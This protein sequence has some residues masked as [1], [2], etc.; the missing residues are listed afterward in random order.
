[1]TEADIP[2]GPRASASAVASAA[3]AVDPQRIPTSRGLTRES[4]RYAARRTTRG[5]WRHRGLDA[6]AALTF[7]ATLA[8]F[9]ATLAIVSI[10]ALASGGKENAADRIT[11][12]LGEFAKP[13]TIASV[14]GPITEFLNLPNPGAAL[15]IGLVVTLWAVSSYATSFGRSINAI[16]EVQEGRRFFKFRALMIAVAGVLMVGFAIIGVIL[17]GTPTVA[18]AIGENLGIAEPWIIA[19]N[20]LKWPALVI[21]AFFIVAVLYYF[22]PNVKHLRLRWVSWGAAIALV[23]WGIATAGFGI[24]VVT[25]DSYNR[26][27]GW[28]GGAVALLIWQYITNLV[29]VMGAEADAE[30]VR[31]RQLAA[32]IAAESVIQLP[33][34]DTKRNL[35]LARQQVQDEAEGKAIRERS[36]ARRSE[37]RRSEG[38]GI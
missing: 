32:G 37:A 28:L 9:P 4:W 5:F 29:L 38:S 25:F 36:E 7:Y 23:A 34:R 2:A 12:I 8:L 3:A 13:S 26:V 14:R 15:L 35:T 21:V 19:W 31:L 16:Y 22:A 33:L 27:Y 18:D 6:A 1:M 11:D 10:F 20:V 30:I 17:L 24:Y